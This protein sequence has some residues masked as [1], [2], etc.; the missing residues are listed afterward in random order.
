MNVG[1]VGFE[2]RAQRVRREGRHGE[3]V[4]GERREE[5]GRELMIKQ[6]RLDDETTR[7]A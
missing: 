1:A 6:R 4:K 7:S 3:A 5:G 2:P